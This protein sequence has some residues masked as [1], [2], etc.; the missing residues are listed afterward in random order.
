MFRGGN[1]YFRNFKQAIADETGVIFILGA[2]LDKLDEVKTKAII[3]N[4]PSEPN[5]C[6]PLLGRKD[7]DNWEP[8]I[9]KLKNLGVNLLSPFGG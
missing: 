2:R 1:F 9:E 5:T 7:W 6:I 3:I 8:V 4:I